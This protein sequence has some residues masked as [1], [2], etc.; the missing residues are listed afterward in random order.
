MCII[1][2]RL[3]RF[4]FCNQKIRIE[5]EA[6]VVEAEKVGYHQLALKC[7]APAYS[8]DSSITLGY[9]VIANIRTLM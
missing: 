4:L 3:L 1:I 8:Y 9:Q 6:K 2:K 7:C 5:L